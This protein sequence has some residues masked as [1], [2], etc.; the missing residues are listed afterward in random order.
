MSEFLVHN[1][2]SA[3]TEFLAKA[4]EIKYAGK[5]ELSNLLLLHNPMSLNA[6]LI[7]TRKTQVSATILCSKT[8][9]MELIRKHANSSTCIDGYDSQCLQCAQE[10][11]QNNQIHPIAFFTAL[12][13]RVS[14][15][16]D[17][18]S[19][20]VIAGQIIQ[21]KTFLSLFIQTIS[22]TFSNPA[23]NKYSWLGSE[24]I[25][26]H[27]FSWSQCE[28]MLL[29]LEGISPCPKCFS[30][31]ILMGKLWTSQSHK[32]QLCLEQ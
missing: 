15:S 8:T 28:G 2:I 21:D 25:F 30:N 27:D 12:S 17:D 22:N 5:K 16:R 9:H 26:S 3:N 31:L 10:M 13:E 14:Q 20:I 24:L 6:P 1:N 11:W 4:C 18:F 7:T 23:N 19:N 29:L 32:F